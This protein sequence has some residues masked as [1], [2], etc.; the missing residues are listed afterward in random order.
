MDKSL[1]VSSR[2]LSSEAAGLSNPKIVT[3]EVLFNGARELLIKH[4]NES[5]RLRITNQG[6][7]ILTK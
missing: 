5:Y 6:K 1:A 2:E 7:L 3:S 4:A